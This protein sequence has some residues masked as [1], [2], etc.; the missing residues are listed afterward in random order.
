[1]PHKRAN[2]SVREKLKNQQYVFISCPKIS[3]QI[4]VLSG[5]D[6]VPERQDLSKEAIPKSFSRVINAL[7]IREQ[8]KAKKR[9]LDEAVHDPLYAEKR[10]RLAKNEEKR[11][12][13]A[14][15]KT[16]GKQITSQLKIKPGESIQHFHRCVGY[17]PRLFIRL[18]LAENRM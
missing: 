4:T 6:I 10:R 5:A 11:T 1:M 7:E 13:S 15:S 14:G 17:E 8:W 12:E 2:R 3:Y 18:A 9:R 16:K